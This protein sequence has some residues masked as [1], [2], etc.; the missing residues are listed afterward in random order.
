MSPPLLSRLHVRTLIISLC[1]LIVVAVLLWAGFHLSVTARE[2]ATAKLVGK[3]QWS[4]GRVAGFSPCG[5]AVVANSNDS[6][7]GS[8]RDAIINACSGDTI[9][10]DTSAGHVMSPITLTSGELLIDKSLT[11]QGPGAGTLTISGNNSSRVF[12]I[13]LNQTANLSGLTIANGQVAGSNGTNKGGGI[14]NAG[15]LTIDSCTISNNTST[16]SGSINFAGGIF[17]ATG[18]LNI[19]NSTVSGNSAVGGC[20]TEGGGITNGGTLTITTSTVSNNS[21]RDAGGCGGVNSGAGIFNNGTLTLTSSTVSGNAASSSNSFNDAGGIFNIFNKLVIVNSTLSGNFVNGG[22]NQGGGVFSG[23]GGSTLII[24]SSTIS[25]NS[26]TNGNS[27]T[28][29][30]IIASNGTGNLRN[31]IVSG[32]SASVGPDL[33][34][35]FTSQGN[36]LI[37]ASDG[38]TGFTNGVNNDQVGS[39]ASPIDA[40]LA[41]LGN[42]GGPTQTHALL[43]GSP[44]LDTGNNCVAN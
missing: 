2:A 19:T 26:A 32:N 23:G 43:A 35:P 10:F 29:G 39:V 36:N 40:L 14:L 8:L 16:G 12:E 21:A 4:R 31:T 42:N 28:G 15:N 25:G 24:S 13:S 34:G 18:T 41:A 11:I 17:N 44:A 33:S 3:S 5:P 20:T 37:S 30:G 7:A 9:S 1:L 22:S 38:N 27:N 6:G